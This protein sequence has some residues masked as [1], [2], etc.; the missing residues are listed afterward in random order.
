MTDARRIVVFDLDQTLGCFTEIGMFW[1]ALNKILK[2]HS[3]EQFFKVM[4]LF[5]EFLR[6]KILTMLKKLLSKKS[7]GKCDKIMIYTNNNGP[8]TWVQ[9]IADY[10][11]Y[12]LGEPVFDVI[13]AFK[14]NNSI[15]EICRTSES[16]N[17]PDLLRCANV[18]PETKICFFDDL[19]HPLMKHDNVYYV[20]IKPFYYSMPYKSM[21]ERYRKH[22]NDGE[23][24]PAFV[25]E[26]VAHMKKNRFTV[27]NKSAS[28]IAVD[29]VVS[30]QMMI[31]IDKFFSKISHSKTINSRIYHLNKTRRR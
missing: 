18:S 2:Y 8:R 29:N 5:P 25:N 10:F 21:A 15:I 22:C 1:S 31:H 12:K 9:M 16:K 6:P 14:F 3:K 7:H 4:D 23:T 20:N 27:I 24:Q 17:T 26:V 13:S 19:Y 30:K 28:E 11:E